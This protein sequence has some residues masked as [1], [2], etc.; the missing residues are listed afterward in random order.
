MQPDPWDVRRATVADAG[1]IARLVNDF[2]LEFDAPSPGVE[3]LSSRLSTLLATPSTLAIVAGRPAIAVAL[4]TLRTNVWFD[5]PVALLDE[6]YVVPDLRDRGI[7]SALM[8]LVIAAAATAG[9]E[10]VETNVDEEDVDA[11]RFYHRHG[12]SGNQP[13]TEERAFYFSRPLGT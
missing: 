2:N 5:G 10:L 6:M 12:F 4:V 13:E 9:A 8:E 11:Q 3:F 1:E 7:G